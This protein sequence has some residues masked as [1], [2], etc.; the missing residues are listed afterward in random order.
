MLFVKLNT[1]PRK[2]FAGFFSVAAITMIVGLGGYWG[3]YRAVSQADA[4]SSQL[5][6]RGRFLAESINLA[7]SAQVNF[8]KQVQEWK[9]ILL[10]GGND[11][12]TYDKYYGNFCDQE[13]A[14]RKDLQ[15][16]RGLL[17]QQGIDVAPVDVCL[18]SHAELG[19]KYRAALQS[20]TPGQPGSAATVD[21]LVKGIDRATTDAIDKIVAMVQQFDANTTAELEQDFH[22]QTSKVETA[23]LIGIII[24]VLLAAGLGFAV[25]RSITGKL[26][27]IAN[28]VETS[29]DQVTSAS[30]QVVNM[31]QSLA[32]GSSEQAASLEETGASLEE[33]SSTIQRNVDSAEEAK[34]LA[35]QTRKVAELG[36]TGMAELSQAVE[37]IRTSGDNVAKIV[38]TIDEIAF[39]TNILALNAAVEAARAGEAG[40]GFAV[41]AEE[42]RNLAQRSAQ[43]AKETAANI[44][45]SL[46]KSRHGVEINGKVAVHLHEIVEKARKLDDLI[47][48]I[49]VASRE[50]SQG[51]GQINTAISQIDQ[52]TQSTA[53]NAE[54][55]AA[56]AE[57]LNAQ[58]Q[59]LRVSTTELL[60]MAGAVATAS[61]E[62]N[63]QSQA[64]RPASC[65]R[66]AEHPSQRTQPQASFFKS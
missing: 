31:S 42:V 27:A 39:Q 33:L 62:T 30:S 9:D 66:R 40:A 1:V 35:S 10:R 26:K 22:R 23:S 5:K 19:E 61:A 65:P 59:M 49:S 46:I 37:A 38:K 28:E 53:A 21:A 52:V 12:A 64:S 57:E 15:A 18:K 36:A 43:S 16:L 24:G 17:A 20:F 56:A 51:V 3:V 7:R 8:K 29:S 58:A 4:I 44:E 48:Q 32:S 11:R 6:Q 50:Q 63:T 14:M 2:L 34:Q 54:E 47:A 25:S 13:A 45:D 60:Q 41:V 55:S